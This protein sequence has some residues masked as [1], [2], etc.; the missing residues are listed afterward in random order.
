MSRW[1]RSRRD[2]LRGLGLGLGCL[3]L[4]EATRSY[5][6]P[7]PRP[8]RFVCV[9]QPFG[10]RETSWLPAV[11][12]PL[13]A[14]PLPDS[15]RPLAPYKDALIFL[16]GLTHPGLTPCPRCGVRA[17]GALFGV[18]LR[19]PGRYL[20]SNITTVDQLGLGVGQGMPPP[21]R[22]LPLGVLVDAGRTA[23]PLGGR[24]CFWRSDG[25]PVDPEES[26]HALFARLFGGSAD[27]EATRR[28][29]LEKRSLLDYVRAELDAYAKPLGH[30]DRIAIQR[31]QESIRQIELD[32]S[33]LPMTGAACAPSLGPPV[34]ARRR[35]NFAAVADLQLK[36]LV[37]ALTCDVTRV[38]TLQLANSA[39]SGLSLDFVPGIP[40]AGG[41][42]W[43]KIAAAPPTP[44]A[45]D[46]KR[47]AD[48]WFM[49]L[50]ARLLAAMST[51]TAGATLL[52]QSAV[53]WATTMSDGPDSNVQKL[54]WLLAG[55]CG[56][57]FKTG[58]VAASTGK[59]LHGVLAEICNAMQMPV[60]FYGDRAFGA[61]MAG[62]KA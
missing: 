30:Q 43:A 10:Y 47:L 38:V 16:P 22:S 4:L 21:L 24:R 7:A 20:E 48:R 13:G 41:A 36:M 19:S 17:Y 2:V 52:D 9:V 49:E 15:T 55:K 8:R 32:L 45:T 1:I 61:P 3:P 26:P 59:P 58:Q 37:A 5:A 35:N 54:P 57:Y 27:A 42:E 25:A 31:H 56:G 62:L 6:Q 33:A 53:L 11:V 39:G 51:G 12:G 14:T 23:L 34:N 50:F 44:S 46:P 60:E 29:R 18:A 40:L 28:L